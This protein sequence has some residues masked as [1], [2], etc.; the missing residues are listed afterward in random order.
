LLLINCPAA[1][2]PRCPAY[3]NP[4]RDTPRNRLELNRVPT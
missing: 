2:L 3:R 4:S 1:A